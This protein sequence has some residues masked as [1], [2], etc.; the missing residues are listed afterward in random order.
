MVYR[1]VDLELDRVV[2]L[3]VIAPEYATDQEFRDRFKRECRLA[4][5]LSHAHVVPIYRAGEEDGHIFVTMAFVEGTDLRALLKEFGALE[6]RRGV[7]LLADVA[8]AL[9]AAHAAGLV[10]RD[11]KPANVLIDGDHAYLT[12]FGLTK[13]TDSRTRMTETGVYV[14]TLDYIAPEQLEGKSVDARTDVYALGC[15]LYEVLTGQVPF[16]RNVDTA[17]MWAHV[18]EPPPA[19]TAVAPKLPPKFDEVVARAMAK[20]PDERYPSAGDLAR[21]AEAALEGRDP[22]SPEMSVAH[23]SAAPGGAKVDRQRRSWRRVAVPI[24]GVLAAAALAA[25]AMALTGGEDPP[26]CKAAAGIG[27]KERP[28]RVYSSFTLQ[29]PG[30]GSAEATVIG[31]RMALAEA[32]GRAGG[33]AVALTSLDSSTATSEGLPDEKQVKSNARRAARD[34]RALAYIGEWESGATSF[35][36]PITNRAGLAQLSPSNTNPGLTVKAPGV[37]EDEPERYYPAK[38]RTYV[39]VMP[40]AVAMA[41]VIAAA[42][43]QS[44]CSSASVITNR[45]DDDPYSMSLD[46][47][48][49][50][51]ASRVGLRLRERIEMAMEKPDLDAVVGAIR[52]ERPRCIVFAAV[53]TEDTPGLLNRLNRAAPNAWIIGGDA[54]GFDEL[55]ATMTAGARVRTRVAMVPLPISAYPAAG[56]AFFRRLRAEYGSEANDPFAAH[57]YEAMKLVLDAIERAGDAGQVDR[58]AVVK[59]LFATRNRKSILGTYSIDRNGDTTL[60]D[61]ALYRPGATRLAFDRV[62]RTPRDLSLTL[63]N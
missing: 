34:A 17:K 40:S 50:R 59:A 8:S 4:A 23:G 45:P 41:A 29:G 3:K 19:P 21:A 15:V 26:A 16:P 36:L 49:R 33:C 51:F 46:A 42:A 56:R 30:A 7:A 22:A 63:E 53:G 1:A 14:G 5:S 25:G 43:K 28:L 11:V 52:R 48:G 37:E 32:G 54:I 10:H 60:S 13:Q 62:V 44:G 39:R 2:A 9:D 24:A 18:G 58:A 47:L 35:S 27:T 20:D 38:R 55:G 31:A 6:P 12:D 61:H 57:G